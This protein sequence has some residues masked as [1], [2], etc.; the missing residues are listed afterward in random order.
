MIINRFASETLYSKLASAETAACTNWHERDSDSP[1]R[2]MMLRLSGK[3]SSA[4]DMR[5][6]LYPTE[7]YLFFAW[8]LLI[9]LFELKSTSR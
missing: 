9:F 3:S 1:W 8:N 5:E 4:E 7:E 6:L 2:S